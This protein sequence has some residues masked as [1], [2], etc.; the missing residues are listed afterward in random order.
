MFKTSDILELPEGS[1]GL[2]R[3]EDGKVV[4]AFLRKQFGIDTEPSFVVTDRVY[5]VEDVISDLYFSDGFST[6]LK[7]LKVLGDKTIQADPDGK[8]PLFDAEELIEELNG[9]SFTLDQEDSFVIQEIMGKVSELE[10]GAVL[11]LGDTDTEFSDFTLAVKIDG[12]W[13]HNNCS[14]ATKLDPSLS[15][16]DGSLKWEEQEYNGRLQVF[17]YTINTKKGE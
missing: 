17:P 5:E 4:Q 2:I 1:I 6:D 12:E 15:M 9:H 3:K 13:H 11:V 10:E 7:Y 8:L 16:I 14:I